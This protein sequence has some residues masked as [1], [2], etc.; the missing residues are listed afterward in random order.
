M[1]QSDEYKRVRD[2]KFDTSTY[3]II[4]DGRPVRDA[5]TGQLKGTQP[6]KHFKTLNEF[7]TKEFEGFTEAY[8][9]FGEVNFAGLIEELNDAADATEMAAKAKGLDNLTEIEQAGVLLAK[10]VQSYLELNGQRS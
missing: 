7:F 10:M 3:V 9:S 8:K 6:V 1:T 2:Y 4:G 5:K